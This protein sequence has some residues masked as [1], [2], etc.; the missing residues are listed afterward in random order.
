MLTPVVDILQ[1]SSFKPTGIVP[2]SKRLFAG[3]DGKRK[4]PDAKLINEVVLQK[5]LDKIATSMDLNFWSI[6]FFELHDFFHS[7]ILDEHRVFPVGFSKRFRDDVFPCTVQ[8]VC[9]HCVPL[10]WVIFDKRPMSREYIVGLPT[11]QEVKR[12][13]HHFIH[14]DLGHHF[15]PVVD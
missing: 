13:C 8:S 2:S 6:L 9:G 4:G 11:K 7:V 5:R 3:A 12:L 10:I 1:S 14:Y 15:I